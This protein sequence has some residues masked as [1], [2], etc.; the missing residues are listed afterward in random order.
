M[1]LSLSPQNPEEKCVVKSLSGTTLSQRAVLQE[2]GVVL[3][4]TDARAQGAEPLITGGTI[5]SAQIH[6]LLGPLAA[7]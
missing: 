4:H 7:N 1:S 6:S 2:V 5:H 3:K